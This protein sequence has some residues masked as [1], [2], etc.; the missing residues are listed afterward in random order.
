[1]F[2][3]RASDRSTLTFWRTCSAKSKVSARSTTYA[4]WCAVHGG[5]ARQGSAT[6]RTGLPSV[7]RRTSRAAPTSPFVGIS[8]TANT[9]QAVES[10][11][12]KVRSGDWLEE[13]QP[14]EQ[15]R[16]LQP[17]V[18]G[19]RRLPAAIDPKDAAS[20]PAARR[21]RQS[22][23]RR[24]DGDDSDGITFGKLPPET[25]F[26]LVLPPNLKEAGTNTALTV[27]RTTMRTGAYP[28]LVK[29]PRSFG[30]LERWPIQRCRSRCAISSPV[31]R[32]R[33]RRH[34]SQSCDRPASRT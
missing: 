22:S 12:F 5:V 4:R 33:H 9:K 26:T 11:A 3:F 1:M 32:G 2:L 6:P 10:C 24:S 15:G 30:I 17:A 27:K 8:P 25:R 21:C 29:F 20:L 18:N 23:T 16:R 31:R 19:P 14:R 28:P 13:L 7:A 34:R